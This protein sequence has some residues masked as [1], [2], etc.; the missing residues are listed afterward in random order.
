MKSPHSR[1]RVCRITSLF[2][3]RLLALCAMFMFL[4]CRSQN[5]HAP[6]GGTVFIGVTGDFDSFNELNAA[7]GEALQVIQYML[8]MCLTALDENFQFAPQLAESWEFSPGDTV[9]TYH[10]R[11]DV[12]WTDG[13][14]TTA[15]DVLFTYQLATNPVVA[16]PAATR[17]DQT[18]KVEILDEYTIRF[19]FKQPYPD[20]LLDTQMPIL[21]K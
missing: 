2:L 19:H 7:D 3:K 12:L 15:E 14:P 6:L 20:A 10:L 21:P 5:Q 8:F 18:G 9:L 4:A 13:A 16:Y 11:K 17:F 1:G